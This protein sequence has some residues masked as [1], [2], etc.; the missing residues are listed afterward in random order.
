MY[1]TNDLPLHEGQVPSPEDP[2]GIA[3]YAVE[4]DLK[5]AHDLFGLDFVIFRPHNVYGPGQNIGD[6]YRNVVGIFMNQVLKG[7]ALTI[8]GDGQQTRAFSY[9]DD[10]A[11]YIAAAVDIAEAR[12]K[13]FNIGGEQPYSVNELAAATQRIMEVEVGINHLEKREEVE[14]AYAD[15]TRFKHVFKPKPPVELNV[16][17]K[18][19]ADWVKEHGALESQPFGKIEI[20]KKT[21]TFLAI[22]L[23]CTWKINHWYQSLWLLRIQRLI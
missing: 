14:H 6:K 18:V 21:A 23:F 19:M 13:V 20:K 1:G 8:F 7:E 10:V 5:N 12:N 3:K 4:M 2:Y 11:P 15:H 9:I 22:N 16:G 17:L